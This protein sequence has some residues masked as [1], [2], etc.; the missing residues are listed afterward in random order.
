MDL[1]L[2]GKTALVAGAASKR[3]I[4]HAIARRL[5]KEGADI[6]VIDKYT[7]PRSMFVG[8]E[9]WRGLDEVV[10]QI[11]SLRRKAMAVVADISN[12][13]EVDEAV[14]KALKMFGKIDILV[15]SVGI[16]GLSETPL[17]EFPEDIWKR[18]LDVN[19]TGTFLISKAVSKSMVCRG[20][21]GKIVHIASMAGTMGR[22]GEVAYCASKW[23]II[24]LTKT[25]A[26][27]LAPHKINVNAINPGAIVTN[28]R[29]DYFARI[30]KET[31]IACDESRNRDFEK[32]L[33]GIPM[34]RF[35][36]V[37]EIADIAVFLVSDR[38]SYI[39]GETIKVSGGI[40]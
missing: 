32:F 34:G 19:L 40:P 37:D 30:E 11:E 4:G 33:P 20:Q 16:V 23:G 31:G 39:T 14:S 25:L 13:Q 29:D 17:T 6:V 7:A 35:G 36:T 5:A 2:K 9:G 21:G 15:N 18:V 26:I 28:I 22:P 1:G 24:G 10:N 12:S 38:S 27:E 8:D 3:G